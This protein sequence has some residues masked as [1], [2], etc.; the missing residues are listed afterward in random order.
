MGEAKV[1]KTLFLQLLST[2][3]YPLRYL[4]IMKSSGRMGVSS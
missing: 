4:N 2:K 3:N 1:G